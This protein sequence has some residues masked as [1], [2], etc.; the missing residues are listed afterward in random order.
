MVSKDRIKSRCDIAIQN[1]IKESTT[2][3]DLFARPFEL[4]YLKNEDFRNKIRATVVDRVSGNK[5]EQL[6]TQKIGHVL[7]P[8]RDLCDFRKCAIID[9]MDELIYLTLV[10]LIAKPIEE[11]RIQANKKRIF[12]YRYK[13]GN[14]YLFDSQYHFTSF[15][16]EVTRKTKMTKNRVLVEVDISNFY[17]RLNIHRLESTLLSLP[18]ADQDIVK[19]INELLLYW[20]NRNSYGLPV[21]SNASRILA[22]AALINVDNFL[23][24]HEVDFC[25]FV[26]DYRIFARDAETAH[27]HL[28]LLT[29][30]LYREGLFLNTSKTKMKDISAIKANDIKI[31]MDDETQNIA[32][33]VPCEATVNRDDLPKIIRGY[34]GLIPTKF[35]A[36]TNSERAKLK[37]QDPC[38]CIENLTQDA[39]V[40]EEEVKRAIKLIAAHEA[41]TLIEKMPSILKKFPQFI[42]YFIDFIRKYADEIDDPI[43]DEVVDAFKD[44][45]FKENVPEYI[46]VY[47]VRLFK[48]SKQGKSILLQAFR[49][50]RRT[51]GDYIGR[52]LLE[53]FN[54]NLTRADVIEIRESFVR[55]DSWEKRQILR[56]VQNILPEGEKR[57][58]FKDVLIFQ[59]EDLFVKAIIN[60]KSELLA[61]TKF[62]I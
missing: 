2:D 33:E 47:L 21:G 55:S 6:K 42:P 62:D 58:F 10:L 24:S 40:D 60:M 44:Q 11:Q 5:F 4:D 53:S 52:A 17:D 37:K 36:L 59:S 7:V 56:L 23:I 26:D 35:R 45:I 41:F 25:R 51:S 22:E 12:S 30:C 8:K 9:I 32:E 18:K 34:S 14:G 28:A 49:N 19:L 16:K 48:L 57:A 27:I 3:V 38:S 54:G 50:L 46:L 20:A 29:Q 31:L 39:I 43:I 61:I 1:L 13:P 15:R